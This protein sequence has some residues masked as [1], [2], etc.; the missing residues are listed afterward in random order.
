MKRQY[1]LIIIAVV[2]LVVALTL[3][4]PMSL[5]VKLLIR[6]LFIAIFLFGWWF[7]RK[8]NNE[9]AK[10]I[11]FVL[12][13]L[14]IAFLIVTPFTSDFWNLNM[15]TARGFALSKFSD[16][17]IICTVICL[18]FLLSGYRLSE[19]YLAKGNLLWGL[20]IGSFFFVLFGYL[21]LNNPQA[22]PDPVFLS[23]KYPWI[24]LFVFSNSLLEE[25]I[26]RGIFLDKLVRYFKPL[27]S[28]IITSLCFAIPHL[29]V[30]YQPDVIV[31]A[32]IVFILGMICGSAMYYTRSLI[33]PV[34]I[35]AGADLLIIIPVFSTY[36]VAN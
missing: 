12:L 15:D 2:M 21:A 7:F 18:S 28:I 36:G 32:G 34:L 17:I 4:A 35:H 20:I 16:A 29:T 14:N 9:N 25:L 26:F 19:L 24:L 8:K 30:N 33:A 27:G 23:G 31:F 1:Q 3:F 10:H 5:F 22:K 13:V 6:V 11:S